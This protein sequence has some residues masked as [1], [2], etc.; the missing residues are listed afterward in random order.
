MGASLLDEE[1][2]EA[3]RVIPGRWELTGAP[4]WR[5]NVPLDVALS[6]WRNKHKHGVE[7]LEYDDDWGST[8]SISTGF[9]ATHTELAS[10]D[11]RCD[12]RLGDRHAT[13]RRMEG[14]QFVLDRKTGWVICRRYDPVTDTTE[15]WHMGPAQTRPH[16]RAVVPP[17]LH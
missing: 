3:A 1:E 2:A 12:T 10:A 11:R 15:H 14:E 16:A 8:S 17:P 9:D 13:P 6:W 5:V 4:S 7:L